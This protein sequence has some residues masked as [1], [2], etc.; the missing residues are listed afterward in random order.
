MTHF[1][2]TCTCYAYTECKHRLFKNYQQREKLHHLLHVRIVICSYIFSEHAKYAYFFLHITKYHPHGGANE[3]RHKIKS[4]HPPLTWIRFLITKLRMVIV[5]IGTN[6][7][8]IYT[9][10]WFINDTTMH[11]SWFSTFPKM[12]MIQKSNFWKAID[13]SHRIMLVKINSLS[14]IL[15]Q[16][17]RYIRHQ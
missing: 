3:F 5:Y 4:V 11:F 1:S 15:G 10:L 9:I 17:Y 6:I 8:N 14:L 16:F 12:K 7:L 2:H 13:Q